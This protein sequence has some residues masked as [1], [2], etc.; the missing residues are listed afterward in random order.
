MKENE[1]K[2]GLRTTM[3]NAAIRKI[4]KALFE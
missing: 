1:G 2:L 3:N 4:Y